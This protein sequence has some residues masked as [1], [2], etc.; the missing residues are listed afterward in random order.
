M[1]HY[2]HYPAAIGKDHTMNSPQRTESHPVESSPESSEAGERES[3]VVETLSSG[4][5]RLTISPVRGH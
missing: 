2:G 1:G 3:V 4:E 5:R